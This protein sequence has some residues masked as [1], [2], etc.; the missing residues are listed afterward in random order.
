MK[1]HSGETVPVPEIEPRAALERQRAG[2][3]VLVDVREPDE[4]RCGHIP[5]ARHIPLGQLES[6][7]KTLLAEPEIIFVCHSG[8][9]SSAAATALNAAGHARAVNLRGGMVA[10]Q[11]DGLPVTL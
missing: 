4:W 11:G 9:R 6:H 1:W 2:A 3:V 8:A 10:W 7:L 5:E